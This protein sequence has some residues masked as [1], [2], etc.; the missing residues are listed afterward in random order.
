MVDGLFPLAIVTGAAQRLGRAFAFSLARQGYGILLHY[1]S[2][3]DTA[4]S[5]VEAL[6]LTGVPV[7]T[8]S[9]DLTVPEEIDKLFSF[10]DR[11]PHRLQLLVNSAAIMPRGGAQDVTPALWDSVFNLNLR[12]PYLLSQSAFGRMAEGGL[13]V[14]IT[15]AGAFKAWTGYVPY[16]VSKSG[17]EALT[18]VLAKA[19]APRVRVNAIAP[20]LVL[21][22][23]TT[24]PEE[25]GKLINRLPL[26]HSAS[27]DQVCSAL[28]FLVK[29]EAITGQTL[30]VDDGYSLI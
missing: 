5:T 4:A 14:N 29:N 16:V 13:I 28:E 30:V 25:W 23:E 11:L 3:A 27:L 10:V 18:R 6:S 12:A 20:G 22:S 15:D 1:H 19:Y 17:L 7:Y 21:P 24:T 9:V 26:R 2:L 8:L